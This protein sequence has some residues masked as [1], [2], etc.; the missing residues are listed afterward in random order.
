MAAPGRATGPDLVAGLPTRNG[1][2][3]PPAAQLAADLAHEHAPEA[4]HRGAAVRPGRGRQDATPRTAQRPERRAVLAGQRD[5]CAPASADTAPPSAPEGAADRPPTALA[6]PGAGPRRPPCCERWP[7]RLP[8]A[9]NGRLVAASVARSTGRCTR[10]PKR[11]NRRAIW[12]GSSVTPQG[13][14]ITSPTRR[15]VQTGPRKPEAAAP[16]SRRVGSS[17]R[18]SG[19]SFG[20]RPEAGCARSPP[21]QP[22]HTS[23]RQPLAHR[24]SPAPQGGSD[25]RV[26]PAR[27]SQLPGASPPSFAPV[28]S[29]FAGFH[30]PS[31]PG[32]SNIHQCQ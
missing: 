10:G 4:D 11:C 20:G 22:F 2:P 26:L 30:R 15:H 14:R 9:P 8:P 7:A 25:L 5:A 28:Q 31:L 24:S 23:A 18:S 6:R 21:L 13:R 12:E 19:V 32:V 29:G 17:A 1:R 16:R 27:W 3:I